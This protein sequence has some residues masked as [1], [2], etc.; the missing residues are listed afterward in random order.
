MP[1]GTVKTFKGITGIFFKKL[2]PKD[3]LTLPFLVRSA[4]V[5]YEMENGGVHI[6]P[7]NPGDLPWLIEIFSNFLFLKREA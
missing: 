4:V 1:E 3:F 6:V 7:Q 5:R 2:S